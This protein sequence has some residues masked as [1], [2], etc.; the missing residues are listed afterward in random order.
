MGKLVFRRRKVETS[1]SRNR[2]V[3]WSTSGQ[4]KSE[5]ETERKRE[6]YNQY[7]S[8]MQHSLRYNDKCI[9]KADALNNTPNELFQFKETFDG[10][11]FF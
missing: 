3:G 9:S 6:R 5:G 8:S 2:T 10:Y 4:V 11:I 7:L 1:S